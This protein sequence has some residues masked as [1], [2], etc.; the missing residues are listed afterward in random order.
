M[1]CKESIVSP[2]LSENKKKLNRWFCCQGEENVFG[3]Q[4][5]LGDF[6]QYTYSYIKF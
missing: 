1:E 2:Y 3:F 6:H 5:E 4:V